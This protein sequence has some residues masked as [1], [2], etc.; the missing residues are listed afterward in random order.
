LRRMSAFGQ[1]ETFGVAISGTGQPVRL[2]AKHDGV[3][4]LVAFLAHSD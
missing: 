1:E 2:A 4:N 3:G